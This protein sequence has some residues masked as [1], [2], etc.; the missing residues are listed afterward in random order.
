M[1]M[2]VCANYLS[3]ILSQLLRSA[4]WS[5]VANDAF[6]YTRVAFL[7]FCD[8]RL[9]CSELVAPAMAGMARAVVARAL[10][11]AMG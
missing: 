8:T 4:Q 1:P 7:D 6:Y 10:P 2:E 9:Y 3:L 11:P 5:A